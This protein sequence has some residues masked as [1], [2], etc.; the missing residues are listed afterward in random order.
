MWRYM[1][2][3]EN[4]FLYLTAGFMALSFCTKETTYMTVGAF[5]LFL[6]FMFAMHIAGKVPREIDELA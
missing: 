5:L 2:S 6:D 4:K 1:A 3:Q